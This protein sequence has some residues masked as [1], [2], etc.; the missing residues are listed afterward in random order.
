MISKGTR[1]QLTKAF[2]GNTPGV[3]RAIKKGLLV[4]AGAVP[5]SSTLNRRKTSILKRVTRAGRAGMRRAATVI[6]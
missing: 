5:I 1:K 6:K 2:I 3:T 4:A